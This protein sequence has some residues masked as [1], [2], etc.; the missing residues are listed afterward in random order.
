MTILIWALVIV[1][2]L[3][4]VAVFVLRG[5]LSAFEME[6]LNRAVK[7]NYQADRFIELQLAKRAP[8]RRWMLYK[9]NR[10]V[11]EADRA[12]ASRRARQSEAQRR[13]AAEKSLHGRYKDR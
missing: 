4:A 10:L 1:A 12:D 11:R 9:V 8:L 2:V 6:E 5:E 13:S 3:V 7:A